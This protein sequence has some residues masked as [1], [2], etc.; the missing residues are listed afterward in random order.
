MATL[1][2][3]ITDVTGR[4]PESISSITVK[5]PSAR[6][7]GGTELIVSSPATVDFDR[8]TGDV[9]ISGLTGG[10]SWL[11]LEGEGWSDSI[12]LS[13]AEGMATLVEAIA[14]ASGVPG[15]VDY[16]SMLRS[17]GDHAQALARAAVEGEFGDIVRA[18][19]NSATLAAQSATSADSRATSA[20]TSADNAVSRVEALEVLGGLTPGDVTDATMSS[21]ALQSE[22]NFRKSQDLLYTPAKGER[23]GL[24]IWPA[25]HVRNNYGPSW[26]GESYT[27]FIA[28][29]DDRLEG[30]PVIKEQIGTDTDG[31]PIWAYT[32]G[33]QGTP[34]ALLV[35]GTHAIETTGIFAAMRYFTEFV[36]HPEMHV[37]RSRMRLTW[38]PVLTPSGYRTSRY[39]SAGVDPARNFD[40]F[41]EYWVDANGH[42]KGSA[43]M[44]QPTS[45]AVKL[46]LDQYPIA[47]VVDCHTAAGGV[48]WAGPGVWTLGN[49]ALA[50]SAGARFDQVYNSDGAIPTGPYNTGRAGTPQVSYWANK[51]MLF[52]K[53]RY[54]AATL[55][56]ETDIYLGGSESL[57]SI[58]QEGA[59]YYCG[60]IDTFYTEWL[61]NGQAAL[62]PYPR[63]TYGSRTT[64]NHTLSLAEGGTLLDS[65]LFNPLTLDAPPNVPG[66]TPTR[67]LHFVVPGPGQ[68]EIQ[69]V[70]LVA[71]PN[72]NTNEVIV[73]GQIAYYDAPLDG[74]DKSPIG[75]TQSAV[76]LP[77]GGDNGSLVMAF[78][79]YEAGP[80]L[81]RIQ[82]HFALA[83][84]AT[85]PGR[86][87]RMRLFA[88]WF[89]ED[90]TAPSPRVVF[91]G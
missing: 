50:F 78:R 18:A 42:P 69:A 87:V 35:G 37:R 27:D 46:L 60:M 39:N 54:N 53:N 81:K 74:V 17:S 55:L 57:T 21:I 52:D 83:T 7:G 29:I 11:Y 34:H 2:G 6:V 19:Q 30:L 32:A 51:Y 40:Y 26:Q 63:M 48:K 12:A 64:T 89:P 56:I 24:D 82:V 86:V 5:A 61:E 31:S 90:D 9:T 77:K 58:T 36:D 1:T 45:Q 84:P 22:S 71:S 80:S 73:R 44:D 3:K 68:V 33:T 28:G 15:V 67:N 72:E 66:V 75:S 23:A 43:P 79:S 59:R 14:N 41:W 88:R 25:Y 65:N 85:R 10:L 70:A 4:A 38:I 76:T 20:E 8:D 47:A 62:Q 16:I 13:A 91:D 49:R